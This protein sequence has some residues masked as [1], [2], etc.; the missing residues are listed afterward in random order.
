MAILTCHNSL[1]M[2]HSNLS[3]S[4]DKSQCGYVPWQITVGLC[5]MTDHSMAMSH[6]KSQ[7]DDVTW[8]IT[9]WLCHMRYHSVAMSHDRSQPCY[10]TWH[11]MAW[12]CH[13][14]QNSWLAM[15]H[16]TSQPDYVA[17]NITVWLCHMKH[18]SMAMLELCH[19][20]AMLQKMSQP[21]Q[22]LLLKLKQNI[23]TV[24]IISR[25]VLVVQTEQN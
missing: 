6:D 5:H 22:C 19:N 12:L 15:S 2:S 9:V 21:R 20:L 23:I 10:V 3:M 11:I 13:M 14:T 7:W 24:C 8:Q 1:A 4:I 17:W 16:E 18:H 25:K